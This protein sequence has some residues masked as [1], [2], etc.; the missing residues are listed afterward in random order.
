A[1]AQVPPPRLPEVLALVAAAPLD[2]AT[3]RIARL[4]LEGA[5]TDL[6]DPPAELQALAA[7]EPLQPYANFALGLLH[8]RHGRPAE[9]MAAFEREATRPDAAA[10]RARVVELAWQTHD[11]QRLRRL[12]SQ[13]RYAEHFDHRTRLELAV[14]ARDWGRVL[15]LIPA[16]QF[17]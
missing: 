14:A 3:R 6:A 7:A 11:Y 8:V 13:P 2:E 1:A 4:T 12:E 9:A 5:A 10:A 16:S 17:E 15:W